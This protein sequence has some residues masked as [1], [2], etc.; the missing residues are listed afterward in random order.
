MWFVA[1]PIWSGCANIT[2]VK[3]SS[4]YSFVVAY[5]VKYS[6]WKNRDEIRRGEIIILICIEDKPVHV[7]DRDR[8]L[9]RLLVDPKGKLRGFLRRVGCGVVDIKV[10]AKQNIA[11]FIST[12]DYETSGL[13]VHRVKYKDDKFIQYSPSEFP[14]ELAEFNLC[15]HSDVIKNG[16]DHLAILIRAEDHQKFIK[17][18]LIRSRWLNLI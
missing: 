6:Y 2:I 15:R 16:E 7:Y 9:L 12:D 13:F 10:G 8:K 5:D 4:F 11:R 3:G 17:Y 1:F 14:D 18:A